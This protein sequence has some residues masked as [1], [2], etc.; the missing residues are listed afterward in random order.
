LPCFLSNVSPRSCFLFFSVSRSGD[1][2][3]N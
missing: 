2:A 3:W 1:Q